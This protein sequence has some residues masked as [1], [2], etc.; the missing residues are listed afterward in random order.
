[1]PGKPSVYDVHTNAPLS[2]IAS[3]WIVDDSVYV[4]N[5]I[6]PM[7]SVTK[8]SDLIAR[9]DRRDFF[10]L[11][12][13]RPR[14]PGTESQ[15]TGFGV[16]TC[17]YLCRE[18]AVHRDIP[19]EVRDNADEPFRPDLDSTQ[20]VTQ[21]LKIKRDELFA[22]SAFVGTAWAT[23]YTGGVAASNPL[24]FTTQYWSDY[25]TPSTPIEDIDRAKEYMHLLTGFQPNKLV[26]NKCTY[27]VLRAHPT[28]RNRVIQFNQNKPV[29]NAQDLA[30]VFDL[31]EVVVA[32][33]VGNFGPEQGQWI[34]RPI[35]GDDALLCYV[36]DSPSTT[37]PSAG[38]TFSYTGGGQQGYN[39]KI[40]RSRSPLDS[41][42]DR[43]T[44]NFCTD[45][46]VVEDS[47]GVFFN[48]VVAPGTCLAEVVAD[49]TI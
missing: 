10:R 19:D 1:M 6:F 42:F 17:S 40:A 14:A 8:L 38:Y 27:H 39:I 20:Q 21:L 22:A 33:A 28:I 3:K 41:Y 37:N 45:P 13:V 48:Q 32:E 18:Y 30:V 9:Y 4:A 15:G 44:G 12:D 16:G 34:S 2:S 24:A 35:F 26:I 43:I 23:N 47:L 11:L 46:H 31:K 7:V 5:R 29:L 25:A 36:T 49:V